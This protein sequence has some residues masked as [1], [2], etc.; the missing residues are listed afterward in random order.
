MKIK[1]PIIY[2]IAAV[3]AAFTIF[4]FENPEKE[5]INDVAAGYFVPDFDAEKVNTVKVTQLLDGALIKRNG[6]TWD[7]TEIVTPA[8]KEI[9][10]KEEKS[11][12]E[13]KQHRADMS[14]VT[15]ALGI[16][17][18]LGLG[19]LVSDNPSKQSIY[20]VD[21]AAGLKVLAEGSDG[22][23]IFNVIIG[24]N[25]P[26]FDS[27]YIRKGRENKVYLVKRAIV[28]SFSPR[29]YDW[30]E[31]KIWSIEPS[32]LSQVSVQTPKGSWTASKSDDGVWDLKDFGEKANKLA[33]LTAAD[34]ADGVDKK[35]AGLESP[36][37]VLTLKYLKDKEAKLSIG[38]K[39]EKGRS[40]A[41]LEG[42]DETYLIPKEFVE[43]IP[44]EATK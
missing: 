39:D 18:E 19:I 43:S 40:F 30:R 10:A 2:L 5:R 41:I 31:R 38:N 16:F 15:S 35:E 12:P 37:I 32:D 9:L 33:R 44:L 14:R 11:E 13:F 25:G 6:N 20:Q 7:V 4:L 27:T 23:E 3:A 28:G 34:F 24:K 36:T 29:A 21:E 8:K 17:G 22:R 1:R 42:L 26:D